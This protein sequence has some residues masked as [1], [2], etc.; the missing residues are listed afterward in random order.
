MHVIYF[1]FLVTI[2]RLGEKKNNYG[3]SFNFDV[4]KEFYP[5]I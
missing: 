4:F 5:I 2:A 3:Y 1:L